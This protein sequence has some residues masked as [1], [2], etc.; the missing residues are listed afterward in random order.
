MDKTHATRISNT[1]FFKH[2]YLTHPTIIPADAI[3]AAAANMAAQP[4]SHHIRHL[5]VDQL[6]D[7]KNLHIVFADAAATNAAD[8]PNSR[9]TH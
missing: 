4:R 6:R 7:L 1:V 5:G 8:A 3:L 2:K 9:N